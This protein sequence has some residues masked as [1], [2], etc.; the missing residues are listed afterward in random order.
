MPQLLSLVDTRAGTALLFALVTFAVPVVAP[1][2]VL[3][4]DFEDG[5]TQGWARRGTAILA[6][7]NKAAAIGL[8][9]LKT[10]GRTAPWN[11]S[12]VSCEVG[13]T[14]RN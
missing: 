8:H 6:V 3:H 11:L 2:Q 4:H 13:R 5:T 12:E 9:S 1:A 10:T 14:R 7:T